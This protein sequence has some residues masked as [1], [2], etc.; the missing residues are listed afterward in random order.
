VNTPVTLTA[1]PA[2]NSSFAGWSGACTTLTGACPLTL[3]QAQSVT[4]TFA[5]A[6][7]LATL[8]TP[9]PGS[10]FPGTS[11][12]FTWS[13]GTGALEYWLTVGTS[14]G[15]FDVYS[16]SQALTLG[17]TVATLPGGSVPLTVRLYTRF[18][19]GWQYQEVTYT[20]V[21]FTQAALLT[22]TPG[23]TLGVGATPVTWS[24]G[25]GA[26]EYWLTVGT[27][28][29]VFDV[30]NQSQALTLGTT[31]PSLPATGGPLY[32]RVYTRLPATGWAHTEYTFTATAKAALLTPTPGS[33]L[34]MGATA[35]TWSAGTNALEYWLT[36]GTSPG[37]F[38]VYNQSQALTLTT[39]VPS[40][41]A[42]GAPLYVRLYTRYA[43]GWQY[44]EYPYTAAPLSKAALLTPTPGSTLGSSATF[45][46]SA[47]AGA[48]E[49]WLTV[50]T[51]SGVFDG[52]SQ[53]QGLTLTGT[54]TPLPVTGSPLFVRLYT[55]FAAGWQYTEYAYTAGAGAKA[56]LL[57]PTPGSPLGLSATFTWSAGIGALEYWLTVG[58]AS[59]VFDGYSQSQG[60]SLT[61]TVP[62]LPATGGPLFI[63]LYT[64]FPITGWAYTEYAYTA[65]AGVPAALGTPTPGST[66]GSS[67]T[68]TWSAGIGALEYWLTVGTA[69]GVFD[70]YSQSQG[71]GTTR[72][73]AGLPG[74]GPLFVRLYTRFP[75]TGWTYTES[76]YT[77]GP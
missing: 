62:S 37:V 11:V 4:A 51:A 64:R 46:W 16:Q 33:T 52:Y 18:A 57:T 56:A 45:T 48:L 9:T 44:T 67:A 74:S 72:T 15:V 53:S 73:V 30:Y 20:A 25:A 8:L 1:T 35:F 50:G 40:L 26:L 58:T 36:V 75:V 24:A 71:L 60:L 38:D 7:T 21:A 61:G 55:R 5:L 17:T 39:T 69:A 29:G 10:T 2:S 19:A 43:P 66:L 54:A 27:S 68:F 76:S 41:P 77:A 32:L 63:R 13:P 70:L 42:T 34:G 31:V 3:D 28:P 22:P 65:T 47:G 49:Y 59:G 14:S 12:P 23:T 6:D